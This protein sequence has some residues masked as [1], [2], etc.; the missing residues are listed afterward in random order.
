LTGSDAEEPVLLQGVADCVLEEAD[1]LVLIDYKTDRVK[2]G[3][4][5]AGRYAEQL[6]FY[7]EALEKTFGKPV[8]EKLLYSLWLS[9]I[10]VLP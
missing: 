1:G 4:E 10:I 2:T 3:E 5:L 8:R 9:K 7:A 6:G